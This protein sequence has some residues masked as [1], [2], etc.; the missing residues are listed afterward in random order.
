MAG[1]H[2]SSL[3]QPWEGLRLTGFH[4]APSPKIHFKESSDLRTVQTPFNACTNENPDDSPKVMWWDRDRATSDQTRGSWSQ[5]LA[6]S[7]TPLA[8]SE[9]RWAAKCF[10]K[11]VRERVSY[12]ESGKEGGRGV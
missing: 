8:G 4:T 6:L 5:G 11:Q 12:T 7:L 9:H 1:R 2:P 3:C 10:I